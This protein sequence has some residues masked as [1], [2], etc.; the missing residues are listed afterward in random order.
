MHKLSLSS[1]NHISSNFDF[2][3]L[4]K[5]KEKMILL[6]KLN[7]AVYLKISSDYL[8]NTNLKTGLFFLAH[9]KLIF[10]RYGVFTG[11]LT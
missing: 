9:E 10:W 11:Q 6:L 7:K 8:T 4:D 5:Q 3:F 1:E 2:F